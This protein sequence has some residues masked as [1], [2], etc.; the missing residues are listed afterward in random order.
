MTQGVQGHYL[1][2]NNVEEDRDPWPTGKA[3]R[4]SPRG[5]TSRSGAGLTSSP[6]SRI[7]GEKG[8]AVA[9]DHRSD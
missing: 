4:E 6:K 2:R 3:Q 1:G 9:G 8:I 7:D 5:W